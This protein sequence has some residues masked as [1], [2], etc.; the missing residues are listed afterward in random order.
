MLAPIPLSSSTLSNHKLT[1]AKYY[2]PL[3]ATP[4]CSKIFDHVVNVPSHPDVAKLEKPQIEEILSD[5]LTK[6]N[7]G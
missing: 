4:N 2:K 7:A 5:I 1:L 3:A 6:N